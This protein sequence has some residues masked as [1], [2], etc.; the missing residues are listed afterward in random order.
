MRIGRTGRQFCV[1][2]IVGQCLLS[3]TAVA[4]PP[5]EDQKGTIR[6]LLATQ[7]DAWN[8]GDLEGFMAGYWKSPE[9]SFI[10]GAT[11]TRGWQPTLDRYR[12]KYQGEGK[13]TTPA[14][15][16]SAPSGGPG[17]MG[18]LDFF[19]LRVEMLAADAAFVRGHWHLKMK[20][21]DEPGGLFTLILRKFPDGWKIIHDHTS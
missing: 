1:V 14:G 11:E 16:K 3:W 5:S 21:G 4:Q 2:F 8:R 18:K 9:L 12:K 10:S 17:D 6:Q 20:N 15:A 7:V 13:E 19:D